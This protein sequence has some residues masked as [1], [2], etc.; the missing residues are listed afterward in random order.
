MGSLLAALERVQAVS[1]DNDFYNLR[2]ELGA[3]FF[4]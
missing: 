2:P 4:F 1:R 3:L